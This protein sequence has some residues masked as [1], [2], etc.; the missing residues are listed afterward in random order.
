MYLGDEQGMEL[1]FEADPC[2]GKELARD[3]GGHSAGA[4]SSS[5]LEISAER[6]EL[7]GVSALKIPARTDGKFGIR[8]RPK[9]R[10]RMA[11][12]T[13]HS[14]AAIAKEDFDRIGAVI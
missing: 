6:P 12:W 10:E 2:K 9:T 7:A 4:R 5:E 13:G 3:G 8:W 1:G 11:S 14:F